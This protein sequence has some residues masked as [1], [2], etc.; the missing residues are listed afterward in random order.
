[1]ILNYLKLIP[2]LAFIIFSRPGQTQA[3]TSVSIILDT[4]TLPK[5]PSNSVLNV[6]LRGSVKPLTWVKG[7]KLIPGKNS[8]QYTVDFVMEIN[9]PTTVY[10]KFVFNEVE[11]E[12]GDAR[13]IEVQ[14]HQKNLYN[15]KF[16]YVKR[17]GNPFKPYIGKWTLKND[18]WESSD[19]SGV[20]QQINIPNHYTICKEVNTDNSILWK[21]DATSAQGHILWVFNHEQQKID[22]IS[23]FMPF[24]SG[25]GEGQIDE[26]GNVKLKVVFEGE[27]MNTYRIYTYTWINKDEYILKSRRFNHKDEPTGDYYGGVFVRVQK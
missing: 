16:K 26:D 8:N 27:P 17:P 14:P 23:S 18:A 22:H 11:W 12:E 5:Q 24:R 20:K 1:M 21:V 2:V 15:A 3:S 19:E 6:G 10:F 13:V 25:V 9:Q 4:S 7:M